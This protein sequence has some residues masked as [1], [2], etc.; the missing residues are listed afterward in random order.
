MKIY[1]ALFRGINVG[2]KNALPMK[3]LVSVLGDLGA[4]NVKTYIQSGNAVFVSPEKDNKRF[5]AKIS[6]E[7]DKRRGFEPHVLLLEL[8]DLERAMRKNPFPEAVTDPKAL[9]AGFLASAPEKPNLKA[10]EGLKS[11]SERFQLIGKVFYLHAP[12]GIG[13]SKL[14]ANVERLLGVPM[15]DRNWRTVSK[16]WELAQALR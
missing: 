5:S 16:I 11:D 14:A 15:T 4:R 13:R 8:E 10:L 1:I 12:E 7:I 6:S 9:H 3:E 2:G